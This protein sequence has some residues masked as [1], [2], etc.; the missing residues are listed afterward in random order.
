MYACM[1]LCDHNP[2]C[3][4][5][6]MSPGGQCTMYATIFGS[7]FSPGV[8]G[9]LK[10]TRAVHTAGGTSNTG[11]FTAWSV[12]SS[13]RFYSPRT[14]M[15]AAS[16]LVGTLGSGGNFTG[17][18][19]SLAS[20]S[21]RQRHSRHFKVCGMLQAAIRQH[22]PVPPLLSPSSSSRPLAD[23]PRRSLLKQPQ[24]I[25]QRQSLSRLLEASTGAH[26]PIPVSSEALPHILLGRMAHQ[27]GKLRCDHEVKSFFCICV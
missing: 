1:N 17:P 21:S 3:V 5:F 22:Q 14:T 9:L 24:P 10:S 26:L 7:D 18:V 20:G 4:G 6:T 2:D 8:T 12:R 13:S 19:P 11:S 16:P 15:S 23:R 25:R 27:R